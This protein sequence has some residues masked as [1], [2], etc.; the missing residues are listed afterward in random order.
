MTSL[1]VAT[2]ATGFVSA[3]VEIAPCDSRCRYWAKIVRAGENLPLPSAVDGAHDIPGP[4]LRQGD[5]ELF[6]GD[7]LV[8]GEEVHHRKA[9]GW[10]YTCCFAKGTKDGCIRFTYSA[11]IK[12]TMKAGGLP[13]NLLAGAG[14][15]AGLVRM[16]H[17]LRAGI[18]PWPAESNGARAWTAAILATVPAAA[19]VERVRL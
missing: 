5:D 17:A 3:T 15:L 14:D 10:T 13:A 12:K 18:V 16:I 4:Y 8:E 2:A 19:P 1:A 9:R 11:D 7:F 6:A